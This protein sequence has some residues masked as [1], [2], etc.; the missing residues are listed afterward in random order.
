[1]LV[2][3]N[4]SKSSVV[5]LHGDRVKIRVACPPEKNRANAAVIDLLRAVTGA[6]RADV[7]RGRT[8]RHKT[9]ALTGVTVDVVRT[10]LSQ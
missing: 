7:V 5:G 10:R 4:A 3:P 8:A 2:V 1:L 6:R 9:V